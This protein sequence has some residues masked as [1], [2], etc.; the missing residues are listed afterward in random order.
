MPERPDS[1]P[2]SRLSRALHQSTESEAPPAAD[3]DPTVQV[4]AGVAPDGRKDDGRAPSGLRGDEPGT[5]R[6]AGKPKRSLRH[7]LLELPVLILFA[8]IIAVLIKTF[9]AQAFFIPSGSMLPTLHLGDRVLVEKLSYR[10]GEP[11]R[12]DVIVFARSV[13]GQPVDLPWYDDVRVF[14]RELL[15]LPTG[16]EED[17]IKRVVAAGGDVI[18][19][20]GDPR[21]L[22]I[23]GETVDEPYIQDGVDRLSGTFTA[24]NCARFEMARKNGG[25][26]VPPDSVFVMGDNRNNSQDSRVFGPIAENKIVGR[27]FVIIWP[28]GDFGGL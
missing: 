21:R 13:L 19:Y 25:C 22:E 26:V 18:R 28:P 3:R 24:R 4:P 27:A 2:T 16:E 12:G 5:A 6:G 10:F 9:L 20:T 14:L 1:R 8:F 17:Y 15:G 11:D 7:Q 23:N